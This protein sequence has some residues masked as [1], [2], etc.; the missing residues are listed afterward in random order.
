MGNVPPEAVSYLTRDN[1]RL[2]ELKERYPKFT[3]WPHSCWTPWEDKVDLLRFRGEN[4][5]LSQAYFKDT[6]KR[7]EMSTA[8]VE[9]IDQ[10]GLLKTL[11]EDNLFGVKTWDII[12]DHPVTRD[13]L[14]S[15]I[16]ITFLKEMLGWDRGQAVRVLDIGAGYGRFAYRF[17]NTFPAG[18]VTCIDAIPTSTFLCEFYLKFRQAAARTRV[19]PFDEVDHL[20]DRPYDLAINIHSWSE[21]TLEFIRFWLGR[22]RDLKIPYL[23][24]VPHF[25]DF[26]TKEP[27]GSNQS[28]FEEL[29][30]HGFKEMLHQRKFQR[31]TV[32]D[33][34]GVYP[35]DYWIFKRG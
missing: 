28:Y 25:Q 15:I 12:P 3:K 8:Y 30:K 19:V 33:R 4:D 1:P 14:D 16:E 13:L 23:F 9:M 34:Y 18:D 11:Q 20:G 10:M 21:C 35:A 31:S 29:G 26:S 24:V 5:Y 27:D 32:T 17:T 2:Q 22:V 6:L 7:Y